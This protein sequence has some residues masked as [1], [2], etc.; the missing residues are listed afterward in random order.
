M[1]ETQQSLVQDGQLG[2]SRAEILPALGAALR[3]SYEDV[4]HADV[5]ETLRR[6]VEKLEDWELAAMHASRR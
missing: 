1:I 3:D 5:P 4:L 6:L 2:I